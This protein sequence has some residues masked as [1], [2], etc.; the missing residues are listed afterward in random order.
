M[1][2]VTAVKEDESRPPRVPRNV[3]AL[4]A[5]SLFTDI[6]SEMITAIFGYYLLI[7]LKVSTIAV[8]ALDG[9]YSAVP[10]LLALSAGYLADRYRRRKLLAGFG[11]GL[12]ALS[13]LGFPLVGASVGGL[14]LVQGADRLG[15]GMRTA[16]RD[17]MI[18]LSA[19]SAIQGRAFGVH[20]TM[21]TM[22]AV[23]GPAIATVCFS[24]AVTAQA[25]KSIFVTS[26]C[27]ACIGLLIL[28]LFVTDQRGPAAAAGAARPT[29]RS[30]LALLHRGPFRRVCVA[31]TLLA[32]VWISDTF[33]YL[34][35]QQRLDLTAIQFALLAVGTSGSYLLLAVPMGRLAD[36]IGRWRVFYGGHC[37]LLAVYVLLAG[38]VGG[39]LLAVVTLSLHGLYYACT[40]GVLMAYAGP[41]LPTELRTSGM[42]VLQSLRALG[43]FCSSIIFGFA[44]AYMPAGDLALCFAGGLVLMLAIA[45][46]LIDPRRSAVV[47]SAVV[48]TTA[49]DSVAAQ[50]P[51]AGEAQ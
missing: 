45:G 17:A 37:A 1:A 14:G 36:R 13:K 15:K 42:A 5:V 27:S 2:H 51:V 22:G 16:P 41:I 50:S 32:V 7:Y 6:S 18:S 10:A 31:G 24:I 20:R 8:G 23:L 30:G 34:V 29:L 40:D 46:V 12:S 44:W 35:L 21:D 49:V 4:G 43:A 9:L 38:P 3:Y 47:E 26:F 25:F 11:Y 39:A 33:V 19:P 48:E 28:A